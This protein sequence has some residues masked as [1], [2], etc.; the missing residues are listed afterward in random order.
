MHD[1][2]RLAGRQRNGKI[3][4]QLLRLRDRCNLAIA[5]LQ[6]RRAKS[7]PTK[8]HQR[9][10]AGS[11]HALASRGRPKTTPRRS[12]RT[13]SALPIIRWTQIHQIPA[14]DI[15]GW[16]TVPKFGSAGSGGAELEPVPGAT[17]RQS[18]RPRSGSL[19]EPCEQTRRSTCRRCK[20]YAGCRGRSM[21][22]RVRTSIAMSWVHHATACSDA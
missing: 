19:D 5:H 1:R 12:S 7:P 22:I 4:R 18:R 2:C 14:H 8:L 11:C 3:E 16:F 17:T 21:T 9:A 13:R 10:S 20:C 6:R 15:G